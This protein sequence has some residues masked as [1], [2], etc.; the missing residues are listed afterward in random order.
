MRDKKQLWR[1]VRRLHRKLLKAGSEW[2]RYQAG[3]RAQCCQP[4]ETR[5]IN[6]VSRIIS[7]TNPETLN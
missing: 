3:N 1:D 7:V 2:R 6:A 5:I 4:D